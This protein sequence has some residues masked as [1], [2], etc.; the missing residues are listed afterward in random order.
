MIKKLLFGANCFAA[1]ILLIVFPAL[2]A[3]IVVGNFFV[4]AI[5]LGLQLIT[6]RLP[7]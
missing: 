2:H 3:C 4:H 7:T 5:V 6:T 1:A